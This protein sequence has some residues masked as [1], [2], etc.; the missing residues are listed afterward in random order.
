MATISS[1]KHNMVDVD[2]HILSYAHLKVQNQLQNYIFGTM[3]H[4]WC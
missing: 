4:A 3:D 1:F 2:G